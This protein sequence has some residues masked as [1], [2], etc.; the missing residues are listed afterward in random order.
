MLRCCDD[1]RELGILISFYEIS[2]YSCKLIISC[3]TASQRRRKR[4]AAR[5]P[6]DKRVRSEYRNNME[7]IN[8][9]LG[10]SEARGS[11]VLVGAS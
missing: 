4:A 10:A 5:V 6:S 7:Q 1:V 8:S 2:D 11:V 3:A 9:A